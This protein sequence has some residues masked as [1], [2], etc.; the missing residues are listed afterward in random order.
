V[1][2]W[3]L[4]QL[5]YTAAHLSS[6]SS[7]WH[8]T[9]SERHHQQR[10][11][12]L[13][14]PAERKRELRKAEQAAELRRTATQC[15]ALT[16]SLGQAM[17]KG[18]KRANEEDDMFE[19]DE[20]TFDTHGSDSDDGDTAGEDTV[21]VGGLAERAR[22]IIY[23]PEELA[24]DRDY[25]CRV[26]APLAEQLAPIAPFFRRL[27]EERARAAMPPPP[28]RAPPLTRLQATTPEQDARDGRQRVQHLVSELVSLFE[29]MTAHLDGDA[30]PSTQMRVAYYT[31]VVQRLIELAEGRSLNTIQAS[32]L[33]R[34]VAV[35]F[36]DVLT[37]SLQSED[38]SGN[39]LFAWVA[40]P[41]LR[42][43]KREGRL[44]HALIQFD[45]WSRATKKPYHNRLTQPTRKRKRRDSNGREFVVSATH[46]SQPC[47]VNA[48]A[49]AALA[50]LSKT[51]M[52]ALLLA[53]NN[54]S[55]QGNAM[56]EAL[57][58]RAESPIGLYASVH[59]A[60][61]NAPTTTV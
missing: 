47:P 17:G 42:W 2:T 12:F 8:H 15:N 5:A 35:I 37:T 26:F 56:R 16:R 33:A 20:G 29:T 9:T 60:L 30:A 38:S 43:C 22:R 13:S 32:D 59:S 18:T 25:H 39:R 1:G 3:D 4:E 23:D 52:T 40:D 57:R 34:V 41:W 53:A 31:P 24:R 27:R 6:S 11:N 45:A 51:T 28:P 50:A 48:E 36:L 55:H 61:L 7:A 44:V 21:A 54:I 58:E 19:D 14:N 10:A 49:H 46:A